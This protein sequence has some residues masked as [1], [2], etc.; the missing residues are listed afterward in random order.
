MHSAT[1]RIENSAQGLYYQTLLI[2][3]VQQMQ[4]FHSKLVSFI[5]SVASTLALTNTLA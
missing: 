4:R 2:L 3:N 1:S 5:L